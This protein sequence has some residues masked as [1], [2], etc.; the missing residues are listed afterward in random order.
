MRFLLTR[1]AI[2][3]TAALTLGLLP[4]PSARLSDAAKNATVVFLFVAGLG[5]TLYDTL[6]FDHYRP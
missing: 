5:K 6:F 4:S 1:L 2:V 3:A